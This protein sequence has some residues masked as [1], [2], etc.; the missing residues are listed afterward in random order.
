MATAQNMAAPPNLERANTAP[1]LTQ[2]EPEPVAQPMHHS[3]PQDVP[4]AAPNAASLEMVDN[5][6]ATSPPEAAAPLPS[7]PSRAEPT[8]V[9]TEPANT[10]TSDTDAI[11]NMSDIPPNDT[12]THDV[13][14]TGSVEEA[15]LDKQPPEPPTRESEPPAPTPAAQSPAACAPPAPMSTTPAPTKAEPADSR[16]PSRRDSEMRD[17]PALALTVPASDSLSEMP[18]LTLPQALHS[19]VPEPLSAD[20]ADAPRYNR[21]QVKKQSIKERLENA[22]QRGEMPCFC[23]NCGAIETPT[24]RKIWTQEHRG[25]P[26]FYELSDK[27]GFVTT[28][29]IL[30]RDDAGQPK[31]HRI[32]KK[33][34]GPDDHRRDWKEFLLCN[35]KSQYMLL[36]FSPSLTLPTP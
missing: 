35:R 7:Q 24:W 1:E 21:N 9:S 31:L 36:L 11:K 23:N 33:S 14:L 13:A 10:N 17:T 32:V 28:V 22:I 34:L 27:P 6:D 15:R 5:Q 29:D 8:D 4:Q 30:E 3:P 25:V 18:S 12:A 19:E 26:A 2:S 16:P 20:G